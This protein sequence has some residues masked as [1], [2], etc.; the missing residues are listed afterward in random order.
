MEESSYFLAKIS[1]LLMFLFYVSATSGSPEEIEALR[2]LR[3][4]LGIQKSEWPDEIGACKWRGITCWGNRVIGI[5]LMG[6][7]S[8]NG[9]CTVPD[10]IASLTALQHLDLRNA[11]LQGRIPPWLASLGELRTLRLSRNNL[12]GPI[13]PQLSRLSQITYLDLSHN[14][15][16]GT[17]PVSLFNFTG[18]V[19]LNLAANNFSGPLPS[20]VKILRSLQ[21][22]FLSFNAFSGSLPPELTELP[23]LNTL[24]LAV[25][26]FSGPLP[27]G[28]SKMKFLVRL[29]LR[30]NFFNGSVP[31]K[32]KPISKTSR[33]C[34]FNVSNQHRERSCRFFY[35]NRTARAHSILPRSFNSTNGSVIVVSGEIK[36]KGDGVTRN[37]AAI[38]GG[39]AAGLVLILIIGMMVMCILRSEARIV[40]STVGKGPEGIEEIQ[41]ANLGEKFTYAQLVEATNMFH[42]ECLIRVGHSGDFYKGVLEGGAEVV[43]KRIDLN[44]V[45]KGEY[46]RELEVFGK[47]SHTRL[48]PL[49]GHCLDMK[50]EKFLV[51][52]YMP[53]GDLESVLRKKTAH[54]IN[55]FF[56]HPLDWIARLKIVIGIA[57]GLA[58][59]HHECSPPIMHREIKASSIL[60]DDKFE[61]RLGSLS[62]AGSPDE[63]HQPGLVA[64]L[65]AISHSWDQGD[66]GSSMA[67][68][69]NDVY[70]FGKLLLEIISG[71]TSTI[72]YNETHGE[73]SWI[74]NVLAL[75]DTQDKDTLARIVDPYLILDEDL[76]EEVWAVA[77]IA[78]ACLNPRPARRPSMRHVLRALENPHKVLRADSVAERTS[79]YSSWNE[80]FGSC[81]S[82]YGSQRLNIPGTFREEC[83]SNGNSKGRN[84]GG[85]ARPGS[86]DIVSENAQEGSA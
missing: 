58:Y 12:T 24:Q 43:V 19:T 29:D 38:V 17:F 23:K 37:L 5:Q 62:S 76:L 22:L 44:K 59:L 42:S 25:N 72:E 32:L 63:D 40:N 21:R 61:V 71:A 69:A 34:F 3:G 84:R 13:P 79:S 48:V 46:I 66:S 9:N 82:S 77:V 56:L 68:I 33:N 35:R 80:A 53:N 83:M 45:K 2:S 73:S 14:N 8:S 86:N 64:R 1:S 10:P 11:T 47:A 7:S 20:S 16:V 31:E 15:L 67:T 65:L 74:D 41:G 27:Q 18:L 70:N 39:S 85:H 36:K 6:L 30:G 60:L 81:R 28:M 50:E 57:E 54:N 55:N 26:Q 52:K 4:A 75:I 51:Y 49:L 78:K